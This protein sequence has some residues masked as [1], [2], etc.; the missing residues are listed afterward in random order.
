MLLSL[1]SAQGNMNKGICLGQHC[2]PHQRVKGLPWAWEAGGSLGKVGERWC[3]G[4][5][6]LCVYW[7][8]SRAQSLSS[9]MLEKP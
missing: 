3:R 6:F 7:A 2:S 9:R 1:H 8:G 4:I 5:E